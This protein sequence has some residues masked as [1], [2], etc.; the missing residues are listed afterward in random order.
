MS[1]KYKRK[2]K[3]PNKTSLFS[4]S[5]LIGSISDK[6]I[7]LPKEEEEEGRN[8]CLYKVTLMSRVVFA[9]VTLLSVSRFLSTDLFFLRIERDSEITSRHQSESHMWGCRNGCGQRIPASRAFLLT[10]FLAV[11]TGVDWFSPPL[12]PPTHPSKPSTSRLSTPPSPVWRSSRITYTQFLNQQWTVTS[13]PVCCRSGVVCEGE[14]HSEGHQR[15][16]AGTSRWRSLPLWERH[17]R[18]GNKKIKINKQ[19]VHMCFT[20]MY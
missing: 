8:L 20:C 12:P 18:N 7:R 3:F 16:Q 4:C 6:P 10:Y 11:N 17:G 5:T 15:Q 19:L 2:E 1:A 9:P 13:Q 14:H